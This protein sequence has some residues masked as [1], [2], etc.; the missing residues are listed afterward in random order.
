[1]CLH[2]RLQLH[3]NLELAL[4]HSEA[5]HTYARITHGQ[6]LASWH[7]Q[8]QVFLNQGAHRPTTSW[9]LPLVQK[10]IRMLFS[11]RASSAAVSYM[12]LHVET[13]THYE[14]HTLPSFCFASWSHFL[15]Y[16]LLN[17]SCMHSSFSLW[18]PRLPGASHTPFVLP[19]KSHPAWS[20]L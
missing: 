3:N 17:K 18:D 20:E 19:T 7:T 13:G 15:L 6:V 12:T 11:H 16:C 2:L 5:R 10:A 9:M 4:A 14:H 8:G 1:M